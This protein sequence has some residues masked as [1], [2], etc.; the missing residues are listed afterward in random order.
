[1]TISRRRAGVLVRFGSTV[2]DQAGS[3]GPSRSGSSTEEYLRKVEQELATTRELLQT[4]IEE[5][6][7]TNEELQ[8]SN[9]ELETTNEEL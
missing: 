8:S 9:E 3:A 5:Q 6:E 7:T 1:M 2:E 4:V